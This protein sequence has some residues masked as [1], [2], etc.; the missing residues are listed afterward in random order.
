MA[1][2]KLFAYDIAV[3]NSDGKTI[4]YNYINEGKELEVTYKYEIDFHDTSK[5]YFYKG[6]IVI[7]EEVTFM[8]R[9]RKVTSIDNYAFRQC[10][11]LSSVTIP[12]SVTS[13]GEYAFTACIGLTSITI[14]S[15]VK[16]IKE[17]AFNNCYGLTSVYIFDLET[18]LSYDWDSANPLRYAS[19]LY[20]NGEEIKDLV[21]PNGV[22]T[23]GKFAF[24][25]WKGVKSVTIPNSVT[26]IKTDAFWGCS[27]LTSVTIPS[28]VTSIGSSAFAYCSSLLS[29]TIPNGVT[30]IASC[31]FAGLGLT[32]VNIPNSVTSIGEFAFNMRNLTTVVS[33]IL[34]P[35]PIDGRSKTNPT[36]SDNTF[37]NATLLVPKGTIEKYKATEGWKDFIFIEENPNETGILSILYDNDIRE[38]HSLYG[39]KYTTLSKG[40]NIIKMKNG[41]V[42]KVLVK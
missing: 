33:D 16:Y 28:S 8:N 27:N 20:V 37:Y 36:F 2:N 35:F 14:P 19:H 12:N 30:S 24:Y 5:H 4:Y 25:S 29:V 23:I 34:N 9:T 26:S 15:N 31:A 32:S 40:I 22:K 1:N 13:I 18:W 3:E 10:A 21:I 11:E 39:E 17:G 38:I 41:T 42:K 7:P 6:N